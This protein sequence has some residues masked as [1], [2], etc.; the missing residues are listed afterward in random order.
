[1]N[2]LFEEALDESLLAAIA[3]KKMT[4]LQVMSTNWRILYR[5]EVQAQKLADELWFCFCTIPEAA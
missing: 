5:A 3:T 2:N 1:M 4:K